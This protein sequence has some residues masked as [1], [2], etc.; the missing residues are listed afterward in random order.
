MDHSSAPLMPLNTQRL[1]TARSA[2]ENH[3]SKMAPQSPSDVV[4]QLY[5]PAGI[6]PSGGVPHGPVRNPQHY[7]VGAHLELY[8]CGKALFTTQ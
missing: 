2:L 1:E 8:T 7:S 6:C 4:N 3:R 5:L